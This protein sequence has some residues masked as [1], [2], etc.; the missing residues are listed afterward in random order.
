MN[1][2][3]VTM[4]GTGS[5]RPDL[6]R[7]G[8]AQ[9][10]TIGDMNILI[11]CGE[12]TTVQLMK[13]GIPPESITYLFMTHLHSDHLLGYGQFLLGGWGLGRRKLTIVGPKGMKHFHETIIKLFDEDISYRTSLGRPGNGVLDVNII[14]ID[15]PGEIDCGLPVKI[16]T[17]EM[18]H[19]VLTYGFRFEIDDKTVVI[20][21]DTAPTPAIIK[22]AKDADLLVIDACLA[23]TGVYRNTKSPEL[24]KIWDN[25][26]KEHCTPEQAGQIGK[27]AGV[28]T[29]VLTHFL[30]NIIE[31]ETYQ[32]AAN[33]FDGEII[34]GRD[35]QII[36]VSSKAVTR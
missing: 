14:E 13:A 33:I 21:G 5:P 15:G 28:K 24:Q 29:L 22:L 20:S 2:V 17:A 26:Q 36:P 18:V 3:K 32:E 8:P 35:L 30:P 31:E 27:E 9:V 6:E 19:N 25:L 4:L 23:P 10:L 7:S 1:N 34:V 11:D 12:G 16:T